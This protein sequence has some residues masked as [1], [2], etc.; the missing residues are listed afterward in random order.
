M[1]LAKNLAWSKTWWAFGILG[2]SCPGVL[3]LSSLHHSV[4]SVLFSEIGCRDTE[5]G[6]NYI[7]ALNYTISGFPCRNWDTVEIFT[8]YGYIKFAQVFECLRRSFL[9]RVDSKDYAI[10]QASV[11]V[12]PSIP[13][14][15]SI[16]VRYIN[17][18]FRRKHIQPVIFF[19]N[20]NFDN[21]FK[22]IL[23]S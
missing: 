15:F 23:L 4:L 20:F 21:N 16:T 3:T 11:I 5:K 6:E 13:L 2:N 19:Q 17:A 12:R 18:K 14:D 9:A 10:S 8:A 22:P 7:G 1:C